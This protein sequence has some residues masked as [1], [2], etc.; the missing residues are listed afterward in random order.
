M[1]PFKSKCAMRVR[2]EWVSLPDCTGVM[3]RPDGRTSIMTVLGTEDI[4]EWFTV[5]SAI[6][7]CVRPSASSFVAQ[8]M[9]EQ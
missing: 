2:R 1:E 5:Q 4:A 8:C 7:I 3:R 6:T 9:S